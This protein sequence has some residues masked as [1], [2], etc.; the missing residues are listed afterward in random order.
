[1]TTPHMNRQPQGIPVGGQF[2][3]TAHAEPARVTLYGDLSGSITPAGAWVAAFNLGK[4]GLEGDFT[5]YTGG[6]PDAPEGSLNYVSPSGHELVLSGVGTEDFQIHHF[7]PSEENTFT[8][9]AGDGRNP[10]KAAKDIQDALW[11]LEV[12]DAFD[13][14]FSDGN[15]YEIR[16]TEL[17]R[18]A[19]G[20]NYG[21]MMIRDD[22]DNEFT[23][24]HNYDTGET[25]LSIPGYGPLDGPAEGA[26]LDSII[27]D[28]AEEP[29][30]GNNDVAAARAF[31][32]IRAF[33]LKA[34]GAGDRID[35]RKATPVM[36]QMLEISGAV[37]A[38]HPEMSTQQARNI[39]V[40]GASAQMGLDYIDASRRSNESG[41]TGAAA[42]YAI[43]IGSM[44]QLPSQLTEHKDDTA[45][46][47]TA[48]REARSKLGVDGRMLDSFAPNGR[49]P[50]F[51][52]LDNH[53]KTMDDFLSGP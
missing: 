47:R 6:N 34:P 53:L 42:L 7:D 27:V 21:A 24:R 1:M 50:V 10:V 26:A 32:K 3:A 12:R 16:D 44:R 22:D 45:K 11:D 41:N 9:G 30:D 25:S 15:V 28:M 40:A 43:G 38:E 2:A 48:I 51:Q 29:D 49:Q 5:P 18:T 20:E 17:G 8:I 33:A 13:A 39:T 19:D 37:Q 46:M 31:E 36:Q 52:E 4:T 35:A 14:G 23:V